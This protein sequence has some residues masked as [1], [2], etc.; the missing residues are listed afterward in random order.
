MI[1]RLLYLIVSFFVIFLGVYFLGIQLAYILTNKNLLTEG[2]KYSLDY[3]LLFYGGTND[4]FLVLTFIA[5]AIFLDVIYVL[6]FSKKDRERRKEARRLSTE[7]KIQFN[8]L[9][10][11]HETKKRLQRISFNSSGKLTNTRFNFAEKALTFILTLCITVIA[12]SIILLDLYKDKIKKEPLLFSC[13]YTTLMYVEIIMVFI[14]LLI[15]RGHIRDL[16]DDSFDFIKKIYNE[17]IQIITNT[18]AFIRISDV[19]KMNVLKKWRI[20]EETTVRRGGLPVITKKNKIWLD[21]TD[22]HNLIIGT[23]NSGKTYSVIHI[24]I[25]TMRMANESMII[26]DLKGELFK[27]HQKQLIRDG[28]KVLVL[29]FVEP[30][31]SSQWNP[32]GIVIKKYR[33]A[34][35][36][37]NKRIAEDQEANKNI[38]KLNEAKLDL[39]EQ[40]L[41][42]ETLK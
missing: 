26:N 16:Y 9:S 13:S 1:K 33:Q 39:Q 22:S 38:K 27:I 20:G 10:S 29:N 8:H 28:Y 34:Q 21:P 40:A 42:K 12:P 4:Y 35:E 31:K 7:E 14:I 24:M 11:T 36:K 41:K 23:T 3:R 37:T 32:L 17:F 6:F 25:D 19:H 2:F 18:F 30:N 5:S 15:S